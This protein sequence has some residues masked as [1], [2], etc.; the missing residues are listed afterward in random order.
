M[1]STCQVNKYPDH[2]AIIMD[3]NGR[4]A[5]EQGQPRN[6]GHQQ[7]VDSVK[8]TVTFCVQHNIPYLTLFAFGQDNNKRP[9]EEVAFI[10]ALFAYQL[11]S[12]VSDFCERNIK[13]K[14]IGDIHPFNQ[15]V[16][17]AIAHAEQATQHCTGLQLAF[18]LNYSG[19]WDLATAANNLCKKVIEGTLTADQ[20]GAD[21]LAVCL[22]S[23]CLP[24]VDL[25][26]RTSGEAR[27]S[28]FLLWQMA[29]AELYFTPISW[30]D[31]NAVALEDACQWFACKERRFGRISEQL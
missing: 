25:M 24:N 4:W 23:A 5:K 19:R 30:P 11:K 13:I 27:L 20:V 14:V 15:E 7:G 21:T 10:I 9:Q 26:I 17:D 12:N 28:D 2:I 16:A 29:Y 6:L 1:K 31:F 3:G 18:A 8:S 22:P